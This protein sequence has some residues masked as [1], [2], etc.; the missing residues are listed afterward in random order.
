MYLLNKFQQNR[1]GIL[2]ESELCPKVF[3]RLHREKMESGR[4]L[5]C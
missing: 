5:Y 2:K 4:W 1:H 3:K